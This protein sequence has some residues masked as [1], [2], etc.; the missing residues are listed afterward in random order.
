MLGR[1]RCLL[2]LGGVVLVVWF[3]AVVEQGVR[4]VRT[5]H[6]SGSIKLGP[7]MQASPSFSQTGFSL[8]A[9]ERRTT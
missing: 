2:A 8:S 7:L 6:Q 4:L 5:G 9:A 1:A 3:E